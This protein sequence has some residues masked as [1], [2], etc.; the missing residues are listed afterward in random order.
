MQ[1][2][3][4]VGLSRQKHKETLN[5]NAFEGISARYLFDEGQGD[6]VLNRVSSIDP[7]HL[8]LPD[9]IRKKDKSFL[10]FPDRFLRSKHID[11]F[12]MNVMIFIPLGFLVHATFRNRYGNAG[13]IT[14]S[15]AGAG[16]FFTFVAEN[17]EIGVMRT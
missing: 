2:N 6:R 11:H 1:R 17:R 3:Y 10:S 13:W 5:S 16:K 14:V 12:I 9:F 4:E 15:S 8:T 7:L